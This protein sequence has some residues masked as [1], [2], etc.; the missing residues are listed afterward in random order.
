MLR[1]YGYDV[2]SSHEVGLNSED[3][4]I[5][6]DFAISENR[7]VLTNNFGDFVKLYREYLSSGKDHYGLIFTTK[8]TIAVMIKRLK[9]LLQNVTAEQMKN[10]IRWLNEFD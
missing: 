8:C 1:E 9:K 10:Q 5:Q 3:D 4:E 6:F 7:A 2:I